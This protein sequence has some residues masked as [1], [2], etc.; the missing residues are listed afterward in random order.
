MSNIRAIHANVITGPVFHT[1]ARADL[2][3]LHRTRHRHD[4]SH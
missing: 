1:R 3:H 4:R 2:S